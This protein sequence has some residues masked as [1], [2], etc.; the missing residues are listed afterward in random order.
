MAETIESGRLADE[1]RALVNDAETFLRE[2]LSNGSAEAQARAKAAVADL[3][4]RLAGLEQRLNVRAR[5]VDG[6]V[7][8]HPWQSVAVAGG[9]GLL[10]GLILG[11]R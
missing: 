11:R 5:Q 7:H 2:G 9:L 6:Y 8:E 4:E 10:V 3:K 1:L